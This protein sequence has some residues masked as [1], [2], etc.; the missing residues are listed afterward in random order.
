MAIVV[1]AGC[2]PATPSETPAPTAST[3]DPTP[4]PT[5]SATPEHTIAFG[6]DCANVLTVDE[7]HDLIGDGAYPSALTA[8][9]QPGIGTLGGIDC[10]WDAD[11]NGAT[12]PNGVGSIEIR[13]AA[14]STVDSLFVAEVADARC[15]PWT[16]STVCR[17]GR[18]V[19]DVWLMASA[20]S[21]DSE[22]EPHAVLLDSA[23]S[24]AAGRLAAYPAPVPLAA[25]S[26]WWTLGSCADLGVRLGLDAVLGEGYVTGWWEGNPDEQ[27]DFRMTRAQGVEQ[28]C[29]WFPDYTTETG[30]NADAGIISATLWPG[31]GWDAD[32]LLAG[33]TA[34]TVAGAQRAVAG[35]DDPD[36]VYATDGVNA[37]R[38]RTADSAASVDIVAR[39]LAA[40]DR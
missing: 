15:D 22:T 31:G 28:L 34:I 20:V 26:G 10:R 2:A 9:A 13:A 8:G 38:V 39:I 33:G 16:D 29:Q 35:A 18:V 23:L 37:V 21:G 17:L 40:Q 6:G 5:P 7:V 19:G 30:R 4:T 25:T 3:V 11:E 24:S 32:R 36:S 14:L 1:I 27:L 12:G